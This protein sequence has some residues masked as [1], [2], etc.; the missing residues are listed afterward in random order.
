MAEEK[1]GALTTIVK[2][3]LGLTLIA[4]GAAAV[5]GWWGSLVAGFKGCIGLLLI[6]AGLIVLAIAKE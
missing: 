4:L 1:K 6:L 2:T 5:I 3:I